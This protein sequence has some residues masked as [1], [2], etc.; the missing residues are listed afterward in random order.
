[1]REASHKMGNQIGL[2]ESKVD[3]LETEL[4]Q[5][6]TLLREIGFIGGIE[7]LKE[8]AREFLSERERPFSE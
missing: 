3:F 7:T 2:L 1:M 5:L 8:A 4:T 6:D